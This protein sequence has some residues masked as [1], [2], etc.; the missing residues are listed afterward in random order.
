[1]KSTGGSPL[2]FHSFFCLLCGSLS[3]A[4]R[5]TLSYFPYRCVHISVSTI[6]FFRVRSHVS[7]CL[8]LYSR[9]LVLNKLRW[10]YIDKNL[11]KSKPIP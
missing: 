10:H 7:V 3:I 5:P 6:T 1:M 8:F 9:Q 4:N 2:K 11:I